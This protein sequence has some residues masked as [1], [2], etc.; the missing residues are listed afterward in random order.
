MN[1][2][3]LLAASSAAL[4]LA[5]CSPGPDEAAPAASTEVSAS[6]IDA[7]LERLNLAEPGV[8]NWDGK[9]VDGSVVT[10][11]NLSLADGEGAEGSIGELV[12][13]A[14]RLDGEVVMFDSVSIANAVMPDDSNSVTVDRFVL[15]NPG[16]ELARNISIAL[17]ELD[18]EPTMPSAETLS[19]FS[20][21][22][23]T[24]EGLSG[25]LDNAD[26]PAEFSLARFSLS[27]FD[28]E[29][30][31]SAAIENIA[32][33]A[34]A[35]ETGAIS[36]SLDEI[37]M[38]GLASAIMLS[39][40]AAAE[41]GAAAPSIDFNAMNAIDLYDTLAMRG[42]DLNAGGVILDI[43]ELTAEIT[44][45]S[46]GLRSTSSMPRMRLAADQGPLA[47]QLAGGLAMLGYEEIV[48]SA[49]GE[50]VYDAD[51]DRSRTVG[52]N[53]IEMENGFRMDIEQDV[54]G[55]QA[56]SDA[57]L[58]AAM[59]GAIEGGELPPEVFAPL[60][61]HGMALRLED[62]SLLERGLAAAATMQG[63]EPEMLRMQAAGLVTLGLAAAPAEMPAEL[64]ASLSQAL[65]GFINNGGTLH[66]EMAPAEPVSIGALI[67][68]AQQGGALDIASLG[69]TVRNEPPAE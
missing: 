55:I 37:T 34:V 46:D 16:P 10:I 61:L 6:D 38:E 48:L 59:S 52:E 4:V 26:G 39:S 69:L 25:A 27:D 8:F 22:E 28:G 68:S 67:D 14:P 9:S 53:Y 57:Y 32:F 30:L 47:A 43:P 17:L 24:L 65:S 64:T 20:F 56:Y 35:E 1:R 33:N 2:S 36:F 51:E 7:A 49:E 40:I 45:T 58:Q 15:T 21:G 66:V 19:E 44:E 3:L 54:S 18:M 23:I 11:T 31:A 42:F 41:S 63:A 5:A 50:S 12:I 62:R 13:A 60:T 29:E